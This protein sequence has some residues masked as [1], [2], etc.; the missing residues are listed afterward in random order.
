MNEKTTSEEPKP[1]NDQDPNK[2]MIL[3]LRL[4]ITAYGLLTLYAVLKLCGVSI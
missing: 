4:Q 2:S 3:V 1:P